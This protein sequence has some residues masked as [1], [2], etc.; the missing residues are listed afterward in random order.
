MLL[1]V[2]IGL[3]LWMMIVGVAFTDTVVVAKELHPLLT[4]VTLTVYVPAVKPVKLAGL[5]VLLVNVPPL[6]AQL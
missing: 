5:A 6:L 3:L 2:Q 1:P 4:P